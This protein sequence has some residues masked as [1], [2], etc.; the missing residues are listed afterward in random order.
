MSGRSLGRYRLTV[1]AEVAAGTVLPAEDTLF[2]RRVDVLLVPAGATAAQRRRIRM[3]VERASAFVHP[4]TVTVY[5]LEEDEGRWFVT[6]APVAGRS[7]AGLLAAGKL[8]PETAMEIALVLCDVLAEAKEAGVVHGGLH[9]GEV[10]L[11]DDGSITIRGFGLGSL[12][13]T[14]EK[15]LAEPSPAAAY[16]PPEAAPGRLPDHLGDVFACGRILQEML[17]VDGPAGSKL[18]ES[19]Q[20]ILG[21]I[22]DRCLDEDRARRPRSA[23]ELRTPLEELQRELL[24]GPAAEAGAVPEPEAAAVSAGWRQLVPPRWR[25]PTTAL[26]LATIAAV[27]T[28]LVLAGG[29]RGGDS[30]V[31][32][33]PVAPVSGQV[34]LA[35]M[36]FAGPDEGEPRDLAE[37]FSGEV[38]RLLER[39]GGLSVIAAGSALLAARTSPDRPGERLGVAHLLEGSFIWQRGDEFDR[40]EVT[41]RLRRTSDGE[42]LWNETLEAFFGDIVGLQ[43]RVASDVARRLG[44]GRMPDSQRPLTNSAGAYRAYLRG[45]GKSAGPAESELLE[46]AVDD[47]G[48]AALLDPGLLLAHARRARVQARLAVLAADERHLAAARQAIA[49]ARALDA[50]DPEVR[51]AAGELELLSGGDQEVARRELEAA[52]QELP[53]DPGLLRHVAMIDRRQ[54]R[55]D[56]ALEGLAEARRRAPLDLALVADLVGTLAWKRRFGE[57]AGEAERLAEALPGT[58]EPAVWRADLLLR[59]RGATAAARALLEE[60]REDLRGDPRWRQAMLR[61]EILEERYDE[62]LERLSGLGLDEA[63]GRVRRA[64]IRRHMGQAKG[65]AADF[66]RARDLLDDRLEADPAN[67]WLA[68]LLA[69]AY[70]GTGGEHLAARMGQRAVAQLP[71]TTDAVAGVELVERLART[72]VLA[73]DLEHALDEIA[74]LLEIPSPLTPALLRLDPAWRP[75]RDRPRFQALLERYAL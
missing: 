37:G 3:E 4:N 11:A 18:S 51:R 45:V 36:P 5:G 65:A 30:P 1:D 59:Q 61:L 15:E 70:A 6:L 29:E 64:W 57:A 39:E 58:V 23:G 48:Q 17:G 73:G 21:R 54:G 43:G 63:E 7:V 41:V 75:L 35:V 42:L 27:V 22:L 56:P 40:A 67:P 24:R 47:F 28:W 60:V 53:G 25:L 26:L 72:Y 10:V 49:A 44:G 13:R 9:P 38:N 2:D 66:E 31:V 20:E 14:A 8:P 50:T 68:S 46:A 62:A 69:Q 52:L 16:A 55:W 33:E 19:A 74:F 12:R 71:V 34:D 32:E